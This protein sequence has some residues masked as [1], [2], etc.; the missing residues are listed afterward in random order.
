MVLAYMWSTGKSK[1]PW[2][3]SA[4]RSVVMT[5]SQPAE[6]E[7]VV[8]GREGGLHDEGGGSADGFVE[9]GLELAVTEVSDYGVSEV[10]AEGLCYFLGQIA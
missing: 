6:L 7:E 1:K 9:G 3:W 10:E 5:L 4:C 8:Q 2:I